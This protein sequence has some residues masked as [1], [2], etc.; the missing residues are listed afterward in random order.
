VINCASVEAACPR[1]GSQTLS[2]G[3]PPPGPSPGIC[4]VR[5]W[6]SLDAGL[7][8]CCH[9]RRPL[10]LTPIFVEARIRDRLPGRRS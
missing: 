9:H 8:C 10:L 6:R 7:A 1:K 2:P 4:G 5:H 3:S